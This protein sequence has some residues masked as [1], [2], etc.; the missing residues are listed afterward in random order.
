MFNVCLECGAYHAD[1]QIE[2]DLSVAR[3]PACGHAHPFR[4]LP[5]FL[6]CG[7]S[8]TGKSAI[9]NELAGRFDAVVLL[10]GDILWRT[11][12]PFDQEKDSALRSALNAI[13]AATE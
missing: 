10:E 13:E 7:A 8:G 3:C 12:G 1:K 9:C 4:R 5:L 2:P 11:T 6:I